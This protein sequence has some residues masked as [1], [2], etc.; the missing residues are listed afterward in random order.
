MAA[1]LAA[2]ARL[3]RSTEEKPVL[4]L[5]QESR[6]GKEHLSHWPHGGCVSKPDLSSCSHLA[7]A[8]KLLYHYI[9]LTVQKLLH[10]KSVTN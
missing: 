3:G 1:L 7:H 5:Q 6:T 9:L 2:S 10:F 4:G 8:N